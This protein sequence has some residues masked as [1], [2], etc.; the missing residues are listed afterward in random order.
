VRGSLRRGGREREK[1]G[2]R[3]RREKREVERGRRKIKRDGGRFIEWAEREDRGR[4]EG[5][6]KG[7]ARRTGE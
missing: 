1:E 6:A 7:Q 5:Q 4:R 3:Y 2:Q